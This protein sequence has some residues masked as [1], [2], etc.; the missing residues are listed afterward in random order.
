MF[1]R[2]RER[3]C[4]GTG[5]GKEGGQR[6]MK[7]RQSRIQVCGGIGTRGSLN[8]DILA[9]GERFVIEEWRPFRGGSGGERQSKKSKKK[10]RTKGGKGKNCPK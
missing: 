4:V 6:P 2:G 5:T 3:V 9:S 8:F 7:R 1:R 10:T